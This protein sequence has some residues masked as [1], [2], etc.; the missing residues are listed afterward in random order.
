[1][2]NQHAAPARVSFGLAAVAERQHATNE[3]IHYLEICVTNAPAD[4]P[5]RQQARSRLQALGVNVSVK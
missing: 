4:S 2:E 5:L 3:M 1:L